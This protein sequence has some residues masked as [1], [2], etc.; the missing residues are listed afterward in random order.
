M[1]RLL[2][3][4]VLDPDLFD[5]IRMTESLKELWQFAVGIFSLAVILDAELKQNPWI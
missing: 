1:L 3:R 2:I 5:R 4:I